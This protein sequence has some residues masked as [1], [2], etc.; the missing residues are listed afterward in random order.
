[1]TRKQ[2]KGFTLLEIL[3]V[4]AAIGILA[5]IVLV[6]INPNRQIAQARNTARQA[7][8][9]TIQ[10]AVEQYL[11]EK[12]SYPSSISTTPG[13]ICNTGT[14]QIGGST[15][16]SGRVDLREL[17]PDYIAGIPKDPQATGTST[18]YNIL[19][20]PNNNKVAI[21]SD[22][23]E[24]KLISLNPYIV[25]NGLVLNLDAGN[26]ASYPG[27]GNTWFDLSGN[28]NNGTL[29]NGVGFD[30]ANGG[31]LSLDGVDD[32]IL[33]GR[34]PFTGN[35]N[36]SLSWG[37]W[38]YP[39]SSNGNIMSMS[40]SNPQGAWNMPPIAASNQRFRGKIWSNSYLFSSIYSLN[41]WYY[42]VFVWEYSLTS[43]I[44][45][46]FLYV[47]GELQSSQTNINYSSSNLD[48]FIFL[49]QLNPG[50][51]N[52]GMFNG[53]YGLFHIYVNKA[54]TPEEVQQNFNATRGRFG[55]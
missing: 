51:D 27:T 37:V 42:I 33:A 49:G 13:Y 43:F 5:A 6:A 44:R 20:N 36:V 50:A 2:N 48:N 38:V 7:D 12:G 53:K 28:N 26:P 21:S 22:L 46:Q 31:A 52:T 30:S 32:Y 23:A 29:I 11:I 54:L 15:N 8:I 3:L 4:I 17:V 25:T 9:N 19:I 55:L 10:K 40:S 35:S 34:I 1:M 47:N 45:G 41:N 14:E 18:E 39:Q 24:S 16:C